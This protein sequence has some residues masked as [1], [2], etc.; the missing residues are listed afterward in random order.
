MKNIS[1][2]TF[3]VLSLLLSVIAE[4]KKNARSEK[5]EK[6]VSSFRT[7][8]VGRSLLMRWKL[9]QEDNFRLN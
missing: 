2:L 8:L 5:T 9:A 3:L 4:A 6:A 7:L 1:V